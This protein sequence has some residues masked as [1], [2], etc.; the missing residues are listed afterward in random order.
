MIDLKV[1]SNRRD[2]IIVTVLTSGETV[3]D[4]IENRKNQESPNCEASYQ[5]Y[6]PM[7]IARQD[8][9]IEWFGK[10]R[11]GSSRMFDQALSRIVVEATD[12]ASL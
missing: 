1:K 7:F 9:S 5:N 3:E 2:S 10:L 4:F 6:A 11:F 8:Y 12:V